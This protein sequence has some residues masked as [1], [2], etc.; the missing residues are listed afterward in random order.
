MLKLDVAFLYDLL[1]A[2][3]EHKIKPKK[4]AQT[5]IDEVILGHSVAGQHADPV[6]LSTD[7]PGWTTLEQL[8]ER[9]AADASGLEV[10][11]HD[12]VTG[13]A[14]GRRC[15]SV[16]RHRFSGQDANH[17]SEVGRGRDDA[18][19]FHLRPRR[20]HLLPRGAPRSHGR[21][22]AGGGVRPA[23]R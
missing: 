21:P 12:F 15:K 16:F 8:H 22:P 7:V 17:L 10:L 13:R 20:Q 2:S 18:E 9:F 4:F 5:D 6:P 14:A 23:G 1:G 3:Q 19:P 11:A